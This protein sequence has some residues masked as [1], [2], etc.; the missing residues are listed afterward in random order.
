MQKKCVAPLLQTNWR[1]QRF[2]C[3][4]CLS[5][6]FKSKNWGREREQIN[7]EWGMSSLKKEIWTPLMKYHGDVMGVDESAGGKTY[8]SNWTYK[9]KRTTLFSLFIDS[10]KTS[11]SEEWPTTGEPKLRS[12]KDKHINIKGGGTAFLQQINWYLRSTVSA[13]TTSTTPRCGSRWSPWARPRNFLCNPWKT[14]KAVSWINWTQLSVL[15]IHLKRS[16]VLRSRASSQLV[17][18]LN[19][20]PPPWSTGVPWSLRKA[21]A[22]CQSPGSRSSVARSPPWPE[23]RSSTWSDA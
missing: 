16:G 3:D 20:P 15:A 5:Q 4:K 9:R 10:A 17:A 2:T 18:P 22:G 21:L 12:K 7:D 13:H 11:W 6:R 19:C 23:P 1:A 14:K 8:E